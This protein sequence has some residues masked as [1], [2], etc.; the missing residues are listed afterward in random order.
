MY[1]KDKQ[2]YFIF[3][4]IILVVIFAGSAVVNFELGMVGAS[5]FF[6]I[7]L[8]QLV[9]AARTEGEIYTASSRSGLAK[10][11]NVCKCAVW[12]SDLFK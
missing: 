3:L 5:L 7:L 11:R 9:S 6:S 8:I 1:N 2:G 4:L 10:S 12:D